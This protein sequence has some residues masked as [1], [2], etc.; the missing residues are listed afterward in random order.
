[1]LVRQLSFSNPQGEHSPL[2]VVLVLSKLL[3]NKIRRCIVF[4]CVSNCCGPMVSAQALYAT[5]RPERHSV[6][7]KRIKNPHGGFVLLLGRLSSFLRS[8]LSTQNE[9]T[10]PEQTPMPVGLRSRALIGRLSSFL[11]S[12]RNADIATQ[13]EQSQM[14]SDSLPDTLGRLSSLFRSPPDTNEAIELRQLSRPTVSSRCSPHVV[15]VAAMRDKQ[16]LYVARRPETANEKARRIKNPKPWVRVVLFLCCV[17]WYRQ[18]SAQ[19][20][21]NNVI[22]APNSFVQSQFYLIVDIFYYP[23]NDFHVHVCILT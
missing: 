16:A 10:E 18:R 13:L 20:I 22:S 3:R 14:S 23:I 5:R 17:S 21:G 8:P 7:A 9:A 1:M 6:K 11:H 4:E 15:E 2:G 19:P 12:Q